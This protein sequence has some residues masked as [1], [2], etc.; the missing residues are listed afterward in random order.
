MDPWPFVIGAYA[1]AVLGTGGLF[2]A[3]YAG[4]RKAEGEAERLGRRE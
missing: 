3:S 2:A 1:L 4:M